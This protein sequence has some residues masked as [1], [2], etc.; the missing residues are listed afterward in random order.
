MA[1]LSGGGDLLLQ[2]FTPVLH[3]QADGCGSCVE[4]AHFVL[5]DDLPE[6]SD[7]GVHRDPLKLESHRHPTGELTC[8]SSCHFKEI[9]PVGLTRTLVAPFARGP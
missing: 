5:F 8:V 2:R 6:P 7:V 9:V 1:T 4:L 3:Q